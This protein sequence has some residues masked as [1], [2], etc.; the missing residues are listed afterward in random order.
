MLTLTGSVLVFLAVPVG[1]GSAFEVTNV[2]ARQIP[3]TTDV[4]VLYDITGAPPGGA[5]VSM[6][7][8]ATGDAPYDI[9]PDDPALSGDVGGGVSDGTDRRIVWHTGATLPQGTQGDAYRAMVRASEEITIAVPQGVTMELVHIPPGTFT[10]GSPGDERGRDDD[11]DLHQVTLTDGYYIGKHE[12]TQ[13]QWKAIMGENPA[14][15]VMIPGYGLST[16]VGDDFLVYFV[17]WDDIAGAD[18]FVERLNDHLET[19]GF[20]LARSE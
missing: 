3:C 2:R 19:T 14:R 17:S 10:M 13:A 7:F 9:M 1:V 5:A 11:E 12:V 8:S 18:G 16:G 6:A 4:E 20:R 15:E